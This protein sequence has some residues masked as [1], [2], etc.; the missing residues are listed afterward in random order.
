MSKLRWLPEIT[1]CGPAYL[2]YQ[3]ALTLNE[4]ILQSLV[5]TL[6]RANCNLDPLSVIN[7]NEICSAKFLL[8]LRTKL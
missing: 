5:S 1:F 8:T 3:V 7:I 6:I 2:N 4:S